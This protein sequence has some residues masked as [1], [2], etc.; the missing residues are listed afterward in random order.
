MRL[1]FDLDGCVID[2]R[3]ATRVSYEAAGVTQRP[4][5]WFHVGGWA[6]S[7]QRR[8]KNGVYEQML[9]LHGHI[10]PAGRL[11]L[12]TGGVVM[13]GCS[14]ES[15][16]AVL[17]VWPCFARRDIVMCCSHTLEDKL[18][19]LN[20]MDSMGGS[21]AGTPVGLYFD[22]WVHAVDQVSRRTR[23]KAVDASRL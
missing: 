16:E 19:R 4:A 17:S 7:E 1:V 8:V 20:V 2:N 9:R 21:W 18:T 6:T 14:P 15:L 12:Q 10:L 3:V 23:W 22:D 11:L 5:D 13:S